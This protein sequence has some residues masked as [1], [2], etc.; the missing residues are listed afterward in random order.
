MVYVQVMNASPGD[1]PENFSR[2]DGLH[3]SREG[4]DKFL[5]KVVAFVTGVTIADD[6]SE[7]SLNSSFMSEGLN[8]IM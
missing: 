8:S 4:R 7:P 6:I 2:K 5:A 3:Y 1:Q